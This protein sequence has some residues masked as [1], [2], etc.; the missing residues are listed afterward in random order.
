MNKTISVIITVF[1]VIVIAMTAAY[2]WTRTDKTPHDFD[3][4]VTEP[5][6]P[7]I[8]PF[9]EQ[10]T[11]TPSV[12]T[13]SPTTSLPPTSP[14]VTPSPTTPSIAPANTTEEETLVIGTPSGPVRINNVLIY[15]DY[16][17]PQ[18]WGVAVRRTGRYD[19][20]FFNKEKEWFLISL[21][22]SDVS[23]ARRDAEQEFLNILGITEGDA[24]K[25]HVELG[26][27]KDASFDLAGSDYGLSFCPNGIPF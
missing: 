21:Y 24:C 19:I 17:P 11:P 1:I 2:V 8:F 22:D 16:K 6:G 7:P 25:L 15:P 23:A 14:L 3:V 10:T 13:P 20:L 18:D 27:S 4:L 26:V 9:P 12:T 5:E